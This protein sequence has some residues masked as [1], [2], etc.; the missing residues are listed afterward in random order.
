MERIRL[1]RIADA[2]GRT[3]ESA[4]GRMV[5]PG[6]SVRT[7][8]WK[9]YNGLVRLGYGHRVIRETAELGS[10]L[11]PLAS[12]VASLLHRWLLGTHQGAVAHS[13]LDYYLDEFTSDS[14]G[15]PLAR[16]ACCSNG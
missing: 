8:D 11:L 9:G 14:T 7:D 13:H 1:E 2:T 10:K 15:A 3:L 12:R 4:V 5:E 6:S 16:A